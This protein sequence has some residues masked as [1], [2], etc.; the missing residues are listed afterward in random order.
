MSELS[1]VIGEQIN[2]VPTDRES[3]SRSLSRAELSRSSDF[4]AAVR[5][6]PKG[7]RVPLVFDVPHAGRIYPADFEYTCDI[8]DLRKTEDN[9]IDD[10]FSFVPE[11]G[12]ELIIAT[13]PRCYIDVNRAA[14]DIDQELIDGEWDGPLSV[15]EAAE[16][17]TGLV[18]RISLFDRPVYSRKLRAEEIRSRISRFYDP[19]HKALEETLDDVRAEFGQ[20]WHIN[21]HSFPADVAEIGFAADVRNLDLEVADR[22]GTTCEPWFSGYTVDILREMGFSVTLNDPF[23]GAEVIRRTGRPAEG[24]HSLQFEINKR[25]YMDEDTLTHSSGFDPLRA[26]L[27]DFVTQLISALPRVD[28]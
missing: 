12:C 14:T 28:E 19:Y 1:S 26:R 17:G 20:V 3:L 10:L 4:P 9:F 21:C 24:R 11:L 23:V 27:R 18:R 2:V 25:L 5:S 16:R 7:Y 22:N 13:F 6:S 8:Q 15:S